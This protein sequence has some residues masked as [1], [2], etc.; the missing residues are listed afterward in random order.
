MG[1]LP[2]STLATGEF[3]FP[4]HI[5]GPSQ[6]SDEVFVEIW[7]GSEFTV[8]LT[9]KG[10]LWARGWSEHGNLGIGS[11]CLDDTFTREWI[12]CETIPEQTDHRSLNSWEGSLACG[13][14]HCVGLFAPS[15]VI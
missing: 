14:A 10:S 1:Q 9:S 5:A 15:R 3:I 8:G 2:H 12:M 4:T 13:G 11:K 6:E 7:C